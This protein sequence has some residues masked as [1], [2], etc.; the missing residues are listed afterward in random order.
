MQLDLPIVIGEPVPILYIEMDGTGVPVVNK[1][2]IGRQSK[3]EGQPARTREVKLG[4]VFTQTGWDD[5]G[6]S[7]P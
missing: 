3:I 4:C 2:T 7:R 6:Y 5:Q 1:E